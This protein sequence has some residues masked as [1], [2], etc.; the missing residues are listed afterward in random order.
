VGYKEHLI[1]VDAFGDPNV[2]AV[3]MLSL[4]PSHREYT[5]LRRDAKNTPLHSPLDKGGERQRKSLSDPELQV[6]ESRQKSYFQSG[7]HLDW[8]DPAERFLNLI[9]TSVLGTLSFGINRAANVMNV[10]IVKCPTDPVWG[11][12]KEFHSD[13]IS[14]CGSLLIPQLFNESVKLVFVNG[15]GVYKYLKKVPSRACSKSLTLVLL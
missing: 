3:A 13:Y 7:E 1:P 2:A 8:F 5:A 14:N 9:T 12:I 15:S 4:N 11:E 10:D 6:I